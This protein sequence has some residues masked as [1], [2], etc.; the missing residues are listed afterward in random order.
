MH[1]ANTNA[2]YQQQHDLGQ[3]A[4][5]RKDV[6]LSPIS[7]LGADGNMVM[8]S[9]KPS[10]PKEMRRS[11]R[12]RRKSVSRAERMISDVENLYEF[13]ISL[14]ILPEDPLLEKS[15]RRMKERFRSLVNAGV[16]YDQ[17]ELYESSSET[18]S[19]G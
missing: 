1:G 8:E 12:V 5:G 2:N 17:T 9:S 3:A 6:L 7:M 15:L 18:D 13:G 10:R 14:S 11:H 4:E 19:D 16:F